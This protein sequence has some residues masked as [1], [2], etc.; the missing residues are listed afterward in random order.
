MK[1]FST[2]TWVDFALGLSPSQQANEMKNH[3]EGCEK[4]QESYDLWRGVVAASRRE[5][6]Y[7]PSESAVQRAK[8]AFDLRGVWRSFE[9]KPR[10]RLIFDSF[11]QPLREGVRNSMAAKRQLQ[12]RSGRLLIDIDLTKESQGPEGPIFLMGQVLNAGEPEQ[13]VKDFRVLLLRG[14]RF[15]AQSNSSPFGEFRFELGGA[16]N[17]KLLF[18]IEGQDVILISLPEL[19]SRPAKTIG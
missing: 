19:T 17:W 3:L 15:T 13:R 2:E 16:K 14:K 18:E 10:A 1:H 9:R 6:K 11:L 4:C 8:E 12:F 7:R 5:K